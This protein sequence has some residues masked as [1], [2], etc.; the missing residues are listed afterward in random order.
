[1]S[2]IKIKL[3]KCPLCG[4]AAHVWQAWDGEFQAE[5]VFCGVRSSSYSNPDDATNSWNTRSNRTY[6]RTEKKRQKQVT[7][8][9]NLGYRLWDYNCKGM[10]MK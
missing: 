6:T 10:L 4:H 3:N 5:C 8:G 7:A 9:Q 2:M 1:M